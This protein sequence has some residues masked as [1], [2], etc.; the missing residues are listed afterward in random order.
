MSGVAAPL[1][2][3]IATRAEW[4]CEYCLIHE[5]DAGYQ[6]EI[7]HVVSRKHGGPSTLENLAY[8]CMVCNR[9]KGTDLGSLDPMGR[10]VPLFNPRM[11]RW[12]DHFRL[13]GPVIQ[14][15]TSEAEATTKTL[16]LNQADRVVERNRLQQLGRYP[17]FKD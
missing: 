8:A 6:H 16:R 11:Q 13:D 10:L 5:D 2:I 1:R 9:F 14:P 17:R 15:L 4:R 12:S 7:D 3:Q